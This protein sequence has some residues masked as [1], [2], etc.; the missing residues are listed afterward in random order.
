MLL[1]QHCSWLST[2]LNNIVEPELARHQ[3]VTMSNNVVDNIEQCCPNNIVA[4]CFQ[5]LL[6]FG[7]DNITARNAD[8][9]SLYL[10]QNALNM[11]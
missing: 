4:S 9:G 6:I 2:V 3:P 8:I 1:G 5:E 11:Q 7:R 10:H